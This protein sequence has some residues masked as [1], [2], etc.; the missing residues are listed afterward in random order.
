MLS[1]TELRKQCA[2]VLGAVANAPRRVL[3]H[4][5]GKMIGAVIGWEEL[6]RLQK[7]PPAPPPL[8]DTDRKQKA[9]EVFARM[10]E[11]SLPVARAHKALELAREGNDALA[12]AS[13]ELE[14]EELEATYG[15]LSQE[16]M[17]LERPR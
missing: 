14:L 10:Q 7:L 3:I 15:L 12:L 4:R 1:A 8:S 11:L 6:E 16:W 9:R 5:H 17:S 13:A 2:A